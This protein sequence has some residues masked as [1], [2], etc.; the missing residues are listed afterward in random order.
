MICIV[1]AN[2]AIFIATAIGM[3]ILYQ[4]RNNLAAFLKTNAVWIL[5]VGIFFVLYYVFYLKFQRVDGFY[6]YWEKYF[7]P[8]SLSEYPRFIKEILLSILSSFTPLTEKYV[9]LYV[10][11]WLFGMYI[12]FKQKRDIFVICASAIVLYILLFLLRIYPFG[13]H[14]VIGSRLSLYMSPIFYLPCCYALI[15]LAKRGIALRFLTYIIVAFLCYKSILFYKHTYSSGHYIQQTHALITQANKNYTND[16]IILIYN[17]T[18]DAAYKYY[19]FLDSNANPYTLFTD[20]LNKLETIIKSTEAK[21]VYLLG[22]F[23]SKG[24]G[25]WLNNL[26]DLSLKFDKNAKFNYGV[27]GWG[28]FLIE[29]NKSN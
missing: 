5:C 7:L 25:D 29:I 3:G 18:T 12:I 1:F 15:F 8:H 6:T 20:D 2:T 24:G 23:Y 9:W 10:V 26:K 14:E 21:K 27:G 11:M 19:S 4:N 28:S 13:H 17:D 22:S 16:D